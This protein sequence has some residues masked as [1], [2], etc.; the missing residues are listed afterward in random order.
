[1]VNPVGTVDTPTVVDVTIRVNVVHMDVINTV[2]RA[3]ARRN[4]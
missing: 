3:P 4:S 1:M 2:R